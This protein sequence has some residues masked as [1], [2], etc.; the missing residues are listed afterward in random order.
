MAEEKQLTAARYQRQII[1][2]YYADAKLAH[3]RGRLVAWSSALSPMELLLAHD[4][5]TLFPENHAA[6]CGARRVSVDI[7]AA[8]E[9]RDYSV[10][11]C[12]YARTDL[13]SAFMGNDTLSP[14][15]GLAKP[16]FVMA[17]NNSCITVTKWYENLARTFDVPMILID[18]P[19]IH[20]GEIRDADINYIV[21]QFKDVIA[22][23]EEKTGRRY[24]Y[25]RLKEVVRLSKAA[26]D[27]WRATLA[28]GKHKPAPFSCFDAF[29]NL[30][31][32]VCLRGTPEAVTF[33]KVLREEIE[34]KVA[35][36]IGV[37][38]NEQFRL[39]WD[40]IAIWFR[41]RDLSERLAAK[42]AV[43]VAAAYT[44]DGWKYERLDPERALETIALEI[45]DVYINRG[46]DY[47][48]DYICK[49]VDDFSIDGLLMHSA[50]TCKPFFIGQYDL[51]EQI[52]ARKGIPGTIIEGDMTD[53]RVYSE[54]QVN[55]RLEAFME[56]LAARR[57]AS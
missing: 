34:A 18:I 14:I 49:L 22:F 23:L 48:I 16:D 25:D 50:R 39:Y 54:A 21:K 36:G 10:D 53:M 6:M 17:I 33:Y 9:A 26:A 47:R 42:G 3:E 27:E 7:Q 45:A 13:G 44:N 40:N 55:T 29:T 12:S 28:L 4:V 57:A 32:I 5:L 19:F 31:P 15:G 43:L 38:P 56:T 46:I 20:E 30:A 8:A 1:D 37:V 24:D 51:M 41:L 11:L 52:S 35:Q 2:S